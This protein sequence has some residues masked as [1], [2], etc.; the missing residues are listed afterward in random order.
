MS[1]IIGL[2]GGIASGK[3]TVTNML[4]GLNIPVIDADEEARLAVEQGESA[5]TAIVDHFGAEIIREDGSIDRVKLGSIIFH[6]EEARSVLNRIVHP[7]V[8]ERMLAKK[9][10]YKQ[11]GN[12]YIVMDIPLLFESQLTAMVDKVIVV[13]VDDEV[14]LERL[15]IRNGYS[16]AEAQARIASQM[17]LKE[18]RKL[19]DAVINNNQSLEETREQLFTILRNWGYTNAG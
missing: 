18:K 1:L 5:Y 19:A 15:K 16:D 10:Q 17:P 14:Q 7:V 9:E 11:L 6:N 8:R 4:K 3:S 13:Y 12:T 2:T